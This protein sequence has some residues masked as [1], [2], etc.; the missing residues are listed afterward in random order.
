MLSSLSLQVGIHEA[1]R[2]PSYGRWCSCGSAGCAGRESP[3]EL[4]PSSRSAPR[5]RPRWR[6]TPGT[7]SALHAASA[8]AG[9]PSRAARGRSG[10]LP[11]EPGRARTQ[12]GRACPPWHFKQLGSL[13]DTVC[14]SFGRKLPCG[15]WQSTHDMAFSFSLWRCGAGIRPRPGE[16]QD[17]A[18]LVDRRRL[19]RRKPGSPPPGPSL[20]MVWQ[21]TQ[22]TWFFAWALMIRSACDGWLRWHFRQVRSALAGASFAGLM[23]SSGE[24][25]SAC[26]EPGPWQDSQALPSQPR[27]L[28]FSTTWCGFLC[29]R[30][31]EVVVAGRAG[32]RT[33]VASR[34]GRL[35]LL[36][37]A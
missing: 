9:W 34:A 29:E 10:S 24:A 3:A 15:L 35:G 31:G 16:W 33:D 14:C 4:R 21:P 25:D 8:C 7:G 27:A 20:W 1:N 23:M 12:T 6:G 5:P 18:L 28:T 2:A 17:R 22:L 36:R 19:A 26:L 11:G 30:F 13:A 32:F 37:P